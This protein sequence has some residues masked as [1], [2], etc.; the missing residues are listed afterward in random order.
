[1]RKT[2]PFF[3]HCFDKNRL[4]KWI[5]Q[6]YYETLKTEDL[7]ILN[8]IETLKDIGFQ[9]ATK[10]GISIGIEDLKIPPKK[11]QLLKEIEFEVHETTI[12]FTKTRLTALE[13]FQN[14]IDIWHR[15]SELIKLEVVSN[16]EST[17]TLNPVYMMA[18]SGARGN[19][20]QV[21]QLVGMRGF[22]SDPE[23]Q[24]IDYP[25][26]SNFREGLTLTE[27][28]VSCYG[29]RKGLVDTALRT[30]DAGYLTR[31][32]VDV[33]HKLV[34]VKTDCRTK[35]GIFLSEI[36]AESKT[37]CSLQ[38]RLVGRVLADD[39]KI[40]FFSEEENQEKTLLWKCF[41]KNQQIDLPRAKLLASC[42]K[43]VFIRS[44]LTCLKKKRLC[45]LC[46]GW[47]LPHA[48]LAPLGEAVGIL[49][50]Q[51]IGE[52]GTQLTMR[53]F[54]TGGVFSGT[55]SDDFTSPYSG[56]IQ[57]TNPGSMS[58]AIFRSLNGKIGF[59][60][61]QP[62]KFVIQNFEF[63]KILFE[64]EFPAASILFF[65]HM[66][67][68]QYGDLLIKLPKQQSTGGETVLNTFTY[69]SNRS[70][71]V[72]LSD[73]EQTISKNV[74]PDI[75]LHK[76]LPKVDPF[77]IK[78]QTYKTGLYSLFIHAGQTVKFSHSEG[79]L[80]KPGDLIN[81][82]SAV[83]QKQWINQSGTSVIFANK[84]VVKPLFQF[85]CNKIQF[86]L[87]YGY[88]LQVNQT[89][90]SFYLALPKLQFNQASSNYLRLFYSPNITSVA[91][92]VIWANSKSCF[93]LPEMQYSQFRID[94][95]TKRKKLPAFKSKFKKQ[96]NGYLLGNFQKEINSIVPIQWVHK[97]QPI[98]HQLNLQNSQMKS[99]RQESGFFVQ[100]T[101]A[102]SD[103]ATINKKRI[104]IDRYW[105]KKTIGY[106]KTGWPICSL[107]ASFQKHRQFTYF[108]QK[109]QNDI[110]F[111]SKVVWIEYLLFCNK[112]LTKASKIQAKQTYLR[113]NQLDFSVFMEKRFVLL[114]TP[115]IDYSF[116]QNR[117]FAEVNPS[118]FQQNHAFLAMK[119]GAI[120]ASLFQTL[121][122]QKTGGI[123]G[124][125]FTSIKLAPFEQKKMNY[126][127]IGS[128]WTP[129]FMKV[130]SG[131][132]WDNFSFNLS[133]ENPFQLQAQFQFTKDLANQNYFQDAFDKPFLREY[134][135][136]TQSPLGLIPPTSP[137]FHSLFWSSQAGECVIARKNEGLV[138]TNNDSFTLKS[139]FKNSQIQIGD[140]IQ[141]TREMS[142]NE[143]TPYT[144][145][146]I[147]IT[148]DF[149]K[150]QIVETSRIYS[151]SRFFCQNKQLIEK[152]TKIFTQS[153]SRLQMGDI[154]QGIP[155]IE[156]FFE[157]RRTKDGVPL[158]NSINRRL[159]RRFKFYVRKCG[160]PH[161]VASRKSI[162][163]IQKLIIDS[164]YQLYKSQGIDLSDKHLEI[165]V[166]Q[167]TAKV[168]I[169]Q[170]W[171]PVGNGQFL[172]YKHPLPGEFYSR[173]YVE[174]Y[175]ARKKNLNEDNV[176]YF[177][178]VLGITRAALENDGFI[179][180]ASFQET[181]RILGRGVV[182][183]KKDYLKG[184]KEN[185]IVGHIVPAGTA[186]RTYTR[187]YEAPI[188]EHLWNRLIYSVLTVNYEWKLASRSLSSLDNHSL[189]REFSNPRTNQYWNPIRLTILRLLV[190]QYLKKF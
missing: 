177:P 112:D 22:M 96:K 30:A 56:F 8:F 169:I 117:I 155:K 81:T 165:I 149:I 39:I 48:H 158:A 157:A 61:L 69:Y 166:K 10:A 170:F 174:R 23:G 79:F 126:F 154:V 132:Y 138:L 26:R 62:G 153:Y 130:R 44:P 128:S 104:P 21:T 43:R 152:T 102:K 14:F 37:I 108:G 139:N 147:H 125:N 70:G 84:K 28:I 142:R 16:F 110:R 185:V 52:P 55:L 121:N 33:A 6:I 167:M 145:Q 94:Q 160:Y 36:Q 101:L 80:I 187:R 71:L 18:F 47:T 4:K 144:G 32:L 151:N 150:L 114:V 105:Q 9:E 76:N 190:L 66:E 63:N 53:T 103:Q 82:R 98:F 106:F 118:Q 124:S 42:Y 163:E 11:H 49:A 41:R 100:Q 46:Y 90:H 171:T 99:I 59:R 161:Y 91:G 65:K 92:K 189:N 72:T 136:T 57:Y 137:L 115:L 141:P 73:S 85:V 129:L 180:A 86:K 127:P 134:Q 120:D 186:V 181:T 122:K 93:F 27:Y 162:F 175:I 168:K 148:K 45:Q 19:L 172:P 38:D 140:L 176:R 24:I 83:A 68:V 159:F 113:K 156:E 111:A 25:I 109:I 12:Q 133:S 173:Q 13:N 3:D 183:Q 178:V 50:A 31:R 64:F 51:S 116:I 188:M 78:A 2:I 29:A 143:T 17:D 54:H 87:Q 88:C 5:R 40:S 74:H 97:N 34:I 1:M 182:F 35:R 77:Y 75:V 123:R 131:N 67:K 7:T 164:V 135:V 184:L 95:K 107:S 58:G 89:K 60:T 20:S 146:V 179:S 15:T 119:K